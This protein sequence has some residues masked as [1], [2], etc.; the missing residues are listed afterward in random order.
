MRYPINTIISVLLAAVALHAPA[1]RP[2]R[3]PAFPGAEGWGRYVTGGRG[4]EVYHVTNLKD[5][6]PG[7]FRYGC[8]RP[9]TRTIV[10]DVSGTIHLTSKLNITHGNLTIAGQTAPGDGICIAD[11]PVTIG[12]QNVI[13]RYVRFRPGNTSEG[14]PD[15]LGASDTGR[16]MI[17]HCSISWSVDECC[18]VY[19]NRFSTVQWCLISQS[20]RHGGHSK[21]THGYGAMMGG[22]GAS[23]HH[24]LLAH[25]DSRCPR[26]AERPATGARDTTDFRNNVMYNWS[27]LGCY[28]AENMNVNIVGNY[29][30]PGPATTGRGSK[31]LR[32]ICGVGVNEQEGHDM[33]HVWATLFV[34]GNVNSKYADVT[35]NNWS[36]GI[37]TQIDEKYRNNPAQYNLD[38]SKMRLTEPVKYY[39]V[40]THSAED[41]YERVLSYA[42]ASLSRDS[43][44]RL[45]VS[46][47][48]EG[49]ATYTGT[50][51]G[52]APGII[53]VPEDN[54]PADAPAGWTPWPLLVSM[55]APLDTDRDG[56]PDA[57][58]TA[59]GLDP[60]NPADRNQLDEEGYTMLEVYMNSL[61]AHIT[62]AQNEGGTADGYTEMRPEVLDSYEVSVATKLDAGMYFLHGIEL[63]NSRNSGYGTSG[64][65][66]RLGR[67]IDHVLTLPE[68]A[69]V[70][71]VKFEGRCR[72]AMDN[73]S[74]ASLVSINGNTVP[75]GTYAFHK[76]AGTDE[77]FTVKV[78]PAATGT[79]TFRFSGNNPDC[80]IT[81]Y[82]SDIAGVEEI[83]VNGLSLTPEED[84]L[85]PWYN[86]Q[87]MMIPC[88]TAPGIYIHC[89]RKVR[90]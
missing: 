7:S 33:Y 31:V 88:P 45:M 13:V 69:A 47:T 56:M 57:W 72:Y 14:E 37:W 30:K 51:E 54:R 58:E 18:S 60:E 1:Q 75:E 61:V 48:R 36:Y 28:G 59:N 11:Y 35:R 90:L 12:A 25:H 3:T 67:D 50:G 8:E 24:N 42:G 22:E 15:G 23:Y 19:G 20:L 79:L 78:S 62:E 71:A 41:A 83:P 26:L 27:G 65:Y 46:D 89:G 76:G 53:D 86:L 43:H 70:T 5:A 9:G 40:T 64:N 66:I 17:D 82:T 77:E 85:Q 32:R 55:E 29:Y 2:E 74:D 44:D 63:S 52:N 4:G 84:E 68:N 21:E 16:L 6:G 87:G 10:F 34:E 38:Q 80:I 73:Y 49:V 39:H 81:L